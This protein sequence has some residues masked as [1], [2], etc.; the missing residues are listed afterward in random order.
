MC[1]GLRCTNLW[2]SVSCTSLK[3]R[4]DS[5][6]GGSCDRCVASGRECIY[7]TNSKTIHSPTVLAVSPRPDSPRCSNVQ[8]QLTEAGLR[9]ELDDERPDYNIQPSRSQNAVPDEFQSMPA[10]LP[11]S[12]ESLSQLAWTLLI[13][14]ERMTSSISP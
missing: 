7:R 12:G 4:C 10:L 9:E 14:C 6:L 11:I 2:R 8:Q 5:Q 3:L 13:F 1:F